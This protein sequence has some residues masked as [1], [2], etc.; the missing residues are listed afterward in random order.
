MKGSNR[1][2]E[3][4]KMFEDAS[5]SL[6]SWLVFLPLVRGGEG[7]E[8]SL[9]LEFPSDLEEGNKDPSPSWDEVL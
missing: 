7:A 1:F 9:G 6:H 4:E 2:W 3:P 8:K 5:F